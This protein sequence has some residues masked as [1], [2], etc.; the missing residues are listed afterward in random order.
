MAKYVFGVSA[1]A[2]IAATAS[3]AFAQDTVQPGIQNAP[4]QGSTGAAAAQGAQLPAADQQEPSDGV[5]DIIVTAQ[6][7]SETLLRVPASVEVVSGAQ[8]QAAHVNNLANLQEISPS[9]VVTQSSSPSIGTFTIRG[10]GTSVG[11]LGSDQS[12]G[13]YIDGVYRGKPGAALQDLLNIERVEV[14]RGPQSTLFGRNNSAGAINISTSLPNSKEFGMYAEGT[15]GNYNTIEAR[16]SANLPIVTDKLAIR[17]SAAESYRDGLLDAPK[18]PR[19]DLNARDRQSFRG[20]LY[21]TP[22]DRTRIRLIGDYSQINDRCCSYVPLFITDAAATPPY[23]FNVRGGLIG[24]TPPTAGTR[25]VSPSN[26]A[27][28]GTFYRPFDRVTTQ[29]NTSGEKSSDKGVSLEVNQDVGTLTV[30]AIGSL[31]RNKND[32]SLDVDGVNALVG[33]VQSNP[34]SVTTEKSAELRVQ[35]Q[36]GSAIEFV[37][38]GYYFD[39]K[40]EAR[41]LLIASIFAINRNVTFFDSTGVGTTKSGA[42]FGQATYNVTSTLRVTGGLRYLKEKKTADVTVVPGTFSFAGNS[43]RTD[44]ALMGGATIAYQPSRDANFYLRYSRGFK[45]GGINL[46]FTLPI[47]VQNPSFSPETT[48]AYEA[49]AKLRFLDGRLSTNVAVYTQTVNDQQVLA[50]NSTT[51]TFATLNA[52]KLRSRGVEAEI[53]ARPV[54]P[55]TFSAG[56]NYLDAKYESFPGAPPPAGSAVATQDLTNRPPPN[57]PRW[58]LVGGVSLDQ[59][60]NDDVRLLGNLTLRHATS[61]YTD[62]PDTEA[63]KNGKTDFLNASVEL[64]LRNGLGIQFWGRNLTK[65]NAYLTGIGTPGGTGSL[66]VFVNEPRTYGVTLRFRH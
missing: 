22:T 49:G 5:G 23:V 48:D 52:A 39:Q 4:A 9:L 46:L 41:N 15:Y 33:N 50:F 32:T 40:L 21:W 59:P 19:G 58:T 47:T 11:D 10:V 53:L 1:L 30:T 2:L 51:S 13:V 7:R 3:P 43:D 27:A 56:I 26:P 38:G 16:L 44:D 14:L 20:Q 24:F 55:L 36:A 8:L 28:T 25:G 63:F 34:S 45:S 31:R 64:A 57:A 17:L 12:V 62:L 66:S 61:A 18:L 65:Q 29:G 60:I 6:R 54:R 37:L 42:V 35:N